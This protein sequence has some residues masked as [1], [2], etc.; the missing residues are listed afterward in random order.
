MRAITL[1]QQWQRCLDCKD[2][3]ALTTVTPLQQRQQHQLDDSK[4]ACTL[5]T[6]GNNPII[7]KATMP[8]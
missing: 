6:D 7:M 2:A 5:M 4:D 3:C 8:A 1:L